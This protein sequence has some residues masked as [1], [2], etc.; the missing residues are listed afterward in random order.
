M[1][2]RLLAEEPQAKGDAEWLC[3]FNDLMTL[4]MV[5]FV[6]LFSMSSITDPRF[7]NLQTALQ[8]GLGILQAGD[9]ADVAVS[10]PYQV[11]GDDISVQNRDDTSNAKAQTLKEIAETIVQKMRESG[12]VSPV[13]AGE[14]GEIRL[15]SGILFEIG[16]ARIGSRGHPV[17]NAIAEELRKHP[18]HIRVEG[19][20][21]DV[22]I[23]TL[24]YPT[25]W[26]LSAQRAVN[27]VKYLIAGGGILPERFSAVG[28]GASKPCAPNLT[29]EGR[30]KNRRVDIILVEGDS[31]E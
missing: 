22:P 24:Q 20:T 27:V 11:N 5:F 23:Q 10:Q 14:Q 4:L 13:S 30:E 3:T 9:Q 28:Y 16:E 25:N 21:D 18:Y 6:L 8:S 15:E 26:E 12:N 31:N 17:L 19:H 1:R 2:K 29:T 7:K